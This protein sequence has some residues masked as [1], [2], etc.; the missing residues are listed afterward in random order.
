MLIKLIAPNKIYS[1]SP[2]YK[3]LIPQDSKYAFAPEG[4]FLLLFFMEHATSRELFPELAKQAIEN[5]IGVVYVCDKQPKDYI[6]SPNILYIETGWKWFVHL[7]IQ[8]T[9][10]FRGVYANKKAEWLKKRFI[11]T[12]LYKIPDIK[13]LE[14]I[15]NTV[16]MQKAVKN[17]ILINIDGGLGD[18]LLTIPSIKTLAYKGKK[19]S[20]VVRYPEVFEGLDYIEKIYDIKDDIDITKIDKLVYLDFGHFM[21]NYTNDINKQN[22]IFTIANICGLS[23]DELV[24]KKPE[25]ILSDEEKMMFKKYD[26]FLGVTANRSWATLPLELAQ[27]LIDNNSEKSWVTTSLKKLELK[28][29]QMYYGLNI[30]KLFALIYQC[31]YYVGVDTSFL[32]IAGAF[33]K[34]IVLFPTVIPPEWRVSTYKNVKLQEP[35]NCPCYCCVNKSFVVPEK[36]LCE[37]TGRLE[38]FYSIDYDKVFD[39]QKETHGV[40]GDSEMKIAIIIPTAWKSPCLHNLL[41]EIYSSINNVDIFLTAN[42]EKEKLQTY[43]NSSVSYTFMKHNY[44]EFNYS[45]LMNWVI[46]KI[47]HKKYDYILLLND[48]IVPKTKNWID[49]YI[50]EIKKTKANILGVKLLFPG[51]NIIQHFGVVFPPNSNINPDHFKEH[52]KDG[53]EFQ[54]VKEFKA[55]TFACAMLKSSLFDKYWFDEHLAKEL[56]DVDYCLQAGKC[57]VTGNVVLY[58]YESYTRK[59]LGYGGANTK[60]RV[61]WKKK[62]GK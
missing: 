25:I 2:Y 62:W 3:K 18:H 24:I 4:D 48:D 13:T 27:E 51:T 22:R 53:V 30:R 36:R 41:E 61:Y 11:A 52:Y 7:L 1:Y 39:A 40:V 49:I 28:K 55:V 32:H 58:H 5:N 9:I 31:E 19:V 50:D 33:D 15:Q 23:V 21:S 35:E 20:L 29:I 60:D 10:D 47:N 12:N 14:D 56:Q 34:K 45:V 16:K 17:H 44:A 38:C 37:K 57:F 59:L 8:N 43:I 54:G 26:A 6:I 46:K 42:I